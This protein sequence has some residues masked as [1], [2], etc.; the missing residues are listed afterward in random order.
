MIAR[1]ARALA[2]FAAGALVTLAGCTGPSP[3]REDA[4]SPEATTTAEDVRRPY[5][6][7]P[8]GGL[9]YYARFPGGLPSGP[10]DLPMALWL[11]SVTDPTQGA[12]ERSLGLNLYAGLTPDSSLRF[13]DPSSQR[14][15]TDW[16][17]P[18]SAGFVLSDEVDMWAGPGSAEWTGNYPG[19]GPI[20]AGVDTRCGYTVQETL[21]AA[22]PADPMVYANFGKGVTFWESDAEARGFVN[23]PVDVVSA[24]NYWFTDP[25]ICGPSEGGT[26][27]ESPRRLTE[28]ECRL[29][30]NYGWTVQ[31]VRSLVSPAGSKPVWAFIEVGQP[32]ADSPEDPPELAEIRAAAWSSLVHGA[33][34][35]VYF[36]HSF[37]GPCPTHHVLRDCG[38]ELTEGLT[39]LNRE[40]TEHA[41]RVNSPTLVNGVRT[42]GEV[43]ATLKIHGAELVVIAVA[44]GH[45][46]GAVELELVCPVTGDAEVLGEDRA[47]RVVDGRFTDDFAD[48][49]AVHLYRVPADGCDLGVDEVGSA[50]PR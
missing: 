8:D 27:L 36:G 47:V 46:P 10:D 5:V 14:A 42:T 4:G 44:A 29:P 7:Q 38:P 32:F 12:H 13:L 49:T 37:G 41:A 43:D 22:L 17:D 28:Q 18:A 19:Q 48:S 30:A 2:C 45:R 3:E 34:G 35:V 1:R 6:E 20:C 39:R 50:A 31:R 25:N 11:S 15:L 26:M 23:G 9:D 40:L 16:P 24:D 21:R 33:R